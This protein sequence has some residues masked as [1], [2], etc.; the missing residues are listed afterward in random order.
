[1]D[2]A[3]DT[4]SSIG[5][6]WKRRSVFHYLDILAAQAWLE[7]RETGKLSAETR[8]DLGAFEALGLRGRRELLTLQGFLLASNGWSQ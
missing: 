6:T 1:V 7:T 8:H 5:S 2:E 4:V 3:Y